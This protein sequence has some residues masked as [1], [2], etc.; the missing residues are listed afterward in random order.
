M[1]RHSY[2][3]VKFPGDIYRPYIP[4]CV[5][6]PFA[7]IG[8]RSRALLDTGADACVFPRIVTDITQHSLQGE[9]VLSSITRGIGGMDLKTWKHTFVI[10]LY[11]SDQKRIVWE[12]EPEL[13]DC[14]EHNNIPLVMGT[15]CFMEYFKITFNYP[16]KEV[17]IEFD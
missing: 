5:V 2:P 16:Q 3:F 15:K 14:V 9:G 6:N 4:I 10:Q 7:N 1:I 11:T 13:V 17:L 8:V 12:S